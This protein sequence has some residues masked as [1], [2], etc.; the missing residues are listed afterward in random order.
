MK[1]KFLFGD[2]VV[3]DDDLIGVVVKTWE[4]IDV[5]TIYYSVY[6]RQ[7]NSIINYSEDKIERYAVRHKYLNDEEL[8]YQKEYEQRI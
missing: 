2:I 4:N 8:K 1:P 5:K 6:V 7:T 3:V